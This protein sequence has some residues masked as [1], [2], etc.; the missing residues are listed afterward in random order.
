MSDY[1][2][3]CI[4]TI[5]ELKSF[6][7]AAAVLYVS[8]PYLSKVVSSVENE[9]GMK[10]FNR[11]HNP[12]SV[13]PAG[14]CYLQYIED[15]LAAEQKMRTAI[16]EING[17]CA[18]IINL[19]MGSLRGPYL[20]PHLL[21]KF[22]ILYPHITLNIIEESSNKELI[23]SIENGQLDLAIYTSPEVPQTVDSTLLYQERL[24]MVLPPDYPVAELSLENGI[25][26]PE[27]MGRLKSQRFI[28]LSELHGMGVFVRKI[29]K[30]YNF[31]PSMLYVVKNL[32]TA[33]RLAA[34]GFGVTMIPETWKNLI[35]LETE[36]LYFQI[37]DPPVTRSVVMIYKKDKALS[38]AEKAICD[39]SRFFVK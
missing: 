9:L 30:D 29:F 24:L 1:K 11:K 10:I 4:R 17:Q 22:D 20:L 33:H 26:F 27:S 19:G 6:S 36:P 8:Q 3:K 21:Q 14:E 12:I 37:D 15:I 38:M 2:Y 31:V 32:E 16:H 25:L 13:T 28:A 7:K 18:S 35:K 23:K 5:A 39:L 34:S